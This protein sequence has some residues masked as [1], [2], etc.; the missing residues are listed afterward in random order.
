MKHPDVVIVHLR[1]PWDDEDKRE[2]PFWEFTSFGITGCHHS[3]VMNPKKAH[4][5]ERARLAF[6]QGGPD[7]MK[8]VFLSP[9]IGIR[10]YRPR[11]EG[12]DLV[13]AYWHPKG[14][15]FKYEHAPLLIGRDG[16]TDFP[17]LK[18]AIR[19]C[20]RKTWIAKF[21]SKFRSRREFLAL[22]QAKEIIR[23]YKQRRQIASADQIA[24]RY[25]QA[26]PP[27]PK[28]IDSDRKRTYSKYRRKAGKSLREKGRC[29]KRTK[30]RCRS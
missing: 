18:D 16:T 21:S 5:L 8:L 12:K 6:A 4:E 22:N 9:P 20:Y 10:R 25:E 28:K 11:P 19:D 2:D 15:P 3:N 14:M 1:R 13:E 7:G 27:G 30:N 23:K 24:K 26:L 17:L 29:G